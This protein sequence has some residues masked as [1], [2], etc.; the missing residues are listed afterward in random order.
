ML[1]EKGVRMSGNENSHP[2]MIHNQ[3]NWK[4][5][6]LPCLRQDGGRH[7]CTSQSISGFIP[8]F[9]NETF[10][11]YLRASV[12]GFGDLHDHLAPTNICLSICCRRGNHWLFGGRLQRVGSQGSQKRF[13]DI[14]DCK[15]S[16]EEGRYVVP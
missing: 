7:Q 9:N 5:L 3:F 13:R 6:P 8:A 12:L 4:V 16:A 14:S 15:C 2:A 11:P 10:H 1:S